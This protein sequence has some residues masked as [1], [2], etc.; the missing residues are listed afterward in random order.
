MQSACNKCWNRLFK[1]LILEA[2]QEEQDLKELARI[3]SGY[4]L[5]DNWEEN[6]N[7]LPDNVKKSNTYGSFKVCCAKSE[8]GSGNVFLKF[9]TGPPILSK[10]FDFI[11]GKE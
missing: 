7:K 4:K 10:R 3:A 6:F 5:T 2:I 8:Y 11:Y 9:D 1:K